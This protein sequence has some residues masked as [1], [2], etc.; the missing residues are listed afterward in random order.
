MA[1]AADL[2]EREADEIARIMTLE[3]GKPLRVRA[4]RR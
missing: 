1:L 4:V 2:L 3:M